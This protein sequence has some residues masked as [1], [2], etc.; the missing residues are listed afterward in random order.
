MRFTLLAA[1]VL[2][3]V[4]ARAIIRKAD[5][6]ASS[7]L[8]SVIAPTST[9]EGNSLYEI[10]ESDL[11]PI[12][13]TAPTLKRLQEKIEISNSD[14]Y[15]SQTDSYVIPDLSTVEPDSPYVRP[16]P[17]FPNISNA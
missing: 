1:L 2:P 12:P 8:S 13:S 10:L 15:F 5:V 6:D 11:F 7:S 4:F 17:N 16:Y 9:V 3:S 14:F